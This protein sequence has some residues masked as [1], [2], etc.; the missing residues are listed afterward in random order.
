MVKISFITFGCTLNRADSELMMGLL[1][2]EGY[3]I[4]QDP[5][6][7]DLVIINSC[8]VKNLAETK[9]FRALRD[10]KAKDRLVIAAGCVPQAQKDYLTKE[11][12]GISVIGTKQLNR[13]ADVVRET[14]DGNVLQL[15]CDGTNRRHGLPRVRRNSLIGIV[16]IAEG[17]LGSCTYCKSKM[18]RGELSSYAP[19]AILEEVKQSISEG[20]KEIWLTSQDC[21][22][23]GKDID[24]DLMTLLKD[25]LKIEGEFRVRLGMANP[26]FVKDFADQ[27]IEL[28]RNNKDKLFRFIH[29]P[30]QSGNNRILKAMNRYYTKEDYLE[31]CQKLR[32]S[33][34]DITIA[35]DIICG[36]PSETEEEF[37]ETL[38][39]LRQIQPDVINR[40]RFWARPGTVAAEM[41]DQC[42]GTITLERSRRLNRVIKDI[43]KARNRFWESWIGTVLIDDKGRSAEHCEEQ[44]WVGRNYAYKQVVVRG[45]LHAGQ[46][47]VVK[48]S[49]PHIFYLAASKHE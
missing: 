46:T 49:K 6:Q 19:D 14:L 4:T 9:F 25:V 22:A 48:V 24:T 45:D 40:S 17:C 42:S 29:I 32:T 36:F 27:L 1:Q 38:D 12:S 30:L 37:D 47:L 3:A 7:A 28:Y 41:E 33:L 5:A 34:P 2:S 35:T 13:I 43:S 26:N 15:V 10:M 16:P 31:L 20:C 44:G 21:G 39:L 8:S 23:Y 11:L 18:A